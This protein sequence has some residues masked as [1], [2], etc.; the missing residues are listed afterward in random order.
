M[1]VCCKS[2]TN[3]LLTKT[4]ILVCRSMNSLYTICSIIRHNFETGITVGYISSRTEFRIHDTLLGIPQHFRLHNHPVL[5]PLL[6]ME[7]MLK[8]PSRDYGVN[9]QAIYE[10]EVA[11]GFHSFS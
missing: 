5:I 8:E 3:A 6:M 1:M 10:V 2:F 9:D 11:T 7:R 4:V